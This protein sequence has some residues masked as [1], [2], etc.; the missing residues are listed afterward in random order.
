MKSLLQQS[1]DIV[2]FIEFQRVCELIDD[3]NSYS[4]LDIIKDCV[5]IHYNS[6]SMSHLSFITEHFKNRSYYLG[7]FLP[8]H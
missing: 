3:C 8:Q 2:P 4:E 1:I 6:Y 5:K 7:S